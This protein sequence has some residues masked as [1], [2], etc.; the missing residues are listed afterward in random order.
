MKRRKSKY[1]PL[2]LLVLL[3]AMVSFFPEILNSFQL[4]TGG[5]LSPQERQKILSFRPALAFEKMSRPP[6]PDY[7]KL[8]TW[9]AFPF[10]EDEADFAP[11][12]TRFKVA[13]N[14]KMP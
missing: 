11:A 5:G 14:L 12:N 9:A 2:V 7:W 10:R 4:L 6:Q 3:V 1:H 13:V 8:E